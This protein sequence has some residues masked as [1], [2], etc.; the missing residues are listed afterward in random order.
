[1]FFFSIT[2]FSTKLKWNFLIKI[3]SVPILTNILTKDLFIPELI[4][5]LQHLF[6]LINFQYGKKCTLIDF[7]GKISKTN[8]MNL[9]YILLKGTFRAKKKCLLCINNIFLE[10]FN[11]LC[12]YKSLRSIL[13]VRQYIK[14]VSY[15]III[16][17][18]T[19]VKSFIK[20][21]YQTTG[22]YA[23]FLY[24][25]LLLSALILQYEKRIDK[26]IRQEKKRDDN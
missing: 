25:S 11:K 19:S 3:I 12:L 16:K 2:S 7:L 17:L 4:F 1:M 18:Q 13:S 24:L 22:F 15:L 6:C 8:I 9:P 5:H 14:G 20:D 26:T 10:K 23:I 21:L